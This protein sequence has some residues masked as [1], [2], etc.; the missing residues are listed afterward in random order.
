MR[1]ANSNFF[2]KVK[3]LGDQGF[4]CCSFIARTWD[5]QEPCTVF[6]YQVCDSEEEL[7]HQP[8]KATAPGGTMKPYR[9]KPAFP[10]NNLCGILQCAGHNNINLLEGIRLPYS[11]GE[12]AY[13][14]PSGKWGTS[15]EGSRGVN[16]VLAAVRAT[17]PSALTASSAKRSVNFFHASFH[18]RKQSCHGGCQLEGAAELASIFP[19]KVYFTE[20]LLAPFDNFIYNRNFFDCSDNRPYC[21]T[22]GVWSCIACCIRCSGK[23]LQKML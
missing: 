6:F 19:L 7:G 1:L 2:R 5:P 18:P 16:T 4:G 15:F 10:A 14:W 3:S 21:A 11:Q 13:T 20:I 9:R 22:S 12:K 17:L 23:G 8:N